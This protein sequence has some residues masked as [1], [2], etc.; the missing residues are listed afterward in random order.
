MSNEASMIGPRRCAIAGAALVVA[1]ALTAGG[2]SSSSSSSSALACPSKPGTAVTG[3]APAGTGQ[4]AA[5]WT[6][7][8]A[9]IANTR[10][11]ASAIT[12]ADVSKLGAATVTNDVVLTT[13][14]HGDLYALD[15]ATGAILFKTP[16]S[17]GSNAPV[18]VDGDYVIAG[19]S[20]ALSSTQRDMIIAYKLGATGKLPDT[21]GG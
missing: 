11:V 20:A 9:D 12:S 18:A 16:M 3:T 2:C 6:Q 8:G 7:P 1:A 17:A 15:A 10:D 19:A 14:F 5:G 21:V 13:T 4:P